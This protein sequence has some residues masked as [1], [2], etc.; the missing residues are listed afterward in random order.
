MA[1]AD[2][3]MARIRE[4]AAAGEVSFASRERIGFLQPYAQEILDAIGFGDAWVSDQSAFADFWEDPDASA[5]GPRRGLHALRL[6]AAS[7]KLGIPLRKHDLVY[8]AAQRLALSRG[9]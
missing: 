8:E 7:A 6:A 9:S 5:A 1:D 4:L 3:A 2:D